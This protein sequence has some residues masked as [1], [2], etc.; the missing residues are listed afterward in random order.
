MAESKTDL[1]NLCPHGPYI[2]VTHASHYADSVNHVGKC[3]VLMG[4]QSVTPA[5]VSVHF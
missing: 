2:L 4:Y 5:F 1:T 3:A